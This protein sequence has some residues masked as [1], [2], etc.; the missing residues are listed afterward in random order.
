VRRPLPDKALHLLRLL[1]S[2]SAAAGIFA[3]RISEPA[4]HG[5]MD[6]LEKHF[7][8]EQGCDPKLIAKK[9]E[10]MA[11][12]ILDFFRGS[13]GMFY[14]LWSHRHP[15]HSPMGWICGD[16]HWENV[17]SYKG[18]NHV[19]YFDFT[20]FDTACLAPLR[21][22]LGRA[23]T[24]MYLL[25]QGGLAPIFL[26]AY[27]QDLAAGKP[28]HIE[29]EVASGTIARLLDRVKNRS[30]AAFIKENAK[31]GRLRLDGDETFP[32]SRREKTEVTKVFRRWA[33]TMTNPAFFE[34][35]DICGSCSGVGAMGH[36]RYRALVKGRNSPHLIDMKEATPSAA[37]AF[38]SAD[39]GI[40]VNEAERTAEVQRI[41]QYVPIARL[42]WSRTKG[43]SFVFSE[44]QPSEDRVD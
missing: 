24:S 28:Y 14:A 41:I 2:L 39:Q 29:A 16:A 3:D 1:A 11:A 42:G 34:L 5:E 8:G 17:G 18:K 13:A 44:F 26:A 9:R 32:L 12:D 36:R 6:L 25:N 4:V 35:L 43:E 33:A 40:W 7:L 37:V 22:D 27:R 20:D 21:Y 15:G 30:Q 38:S 10:K 31:H 19:A 23:A